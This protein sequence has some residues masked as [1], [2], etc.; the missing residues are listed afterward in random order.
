MRADEDESRPTLIR[1]V[2]A[3]S[4]SQAKVHKPRVKESEVQGI[5]V[6]D[7]SPQFVVTTG[8]KTV[9]VLE[10]K[11]FGGKKRNVSGMSAPDVMKWSRASGTMPFPGS[12]K[13]IFSDLATPEF[14]EKPSI[15]NKRLKQEHRSQLVE[16]KRKRKS[17]DVP[18]HSPELLDTFEVQK[19][20]TF[21]PIRQVKSDVLKPKPISV[22]TK[23]ALGKMMGSVSSLISSSSRNESVELEI[24]KEVKMIRYKIAVLEKKLDDLS[25][26]NSCQKTLKNCPIALP[27][28]MQTIE[29]GEKFVEIE[30]NKKILV[31]YMQSRLN[32]LSSSI[33]KFNKKAMRLM[34]DD[35]VYENFGW[36]KND[37]ERNFAGNYKIFTEFLKG[38][39]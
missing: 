35:L 5:Q 17:M 8:G 25:F 1:I 38:K 15:M 14:N 39:R 7:P 21:S 31:N 18:L 3:N 33:E 23:A 27:L 29:E 37:Q 12:A 28:T 11:E 26:K 32:N 22:D 13:Q 2:A 16:E 6:D 20:Q 4:Q 34:F 19:K 30:E 9:R 36:K 24:L 10:V